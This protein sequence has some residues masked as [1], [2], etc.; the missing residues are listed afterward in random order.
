MPEIDL[1]HRSNKKYLSIPKHQ[2]NARND[3]S[4]W[5][6]IDLEIETFNNGD[7]GSIDGTIKESWLCQTNLWGFSKNND[8]VKIV[9]TEKQQFGFFETPRN[10]TDHWHGYPIIPFKSK[11]KK[12]DICKSLLN[13]W[14]DGEVLTSDEIANLVKGK[15]L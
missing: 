3:H 11:E 4:K 12:H 6:T 13:K 2:K 8:G 10:E 9:G 14:K 15:L 7:N 5:E 1:S